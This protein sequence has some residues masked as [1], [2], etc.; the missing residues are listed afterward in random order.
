MYKLHLY[1][2]G[3]YG[4]LGLKWWKLL[5]FFWAHKLVITS[6]SSENYTDKENEVTLNKGFQET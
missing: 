3:H 4:N 2:I 5:L 1:I 6:Q